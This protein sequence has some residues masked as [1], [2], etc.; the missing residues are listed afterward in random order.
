MS[1]LFG[2]VSQSGYVVP[3]LD[4]AIEA[5]A[6][7][8][9]GPWI[10]HRHVELEWFR[11]RGDD[12]EPDISI[13]L[14]NSGSLQIELIA[15]HNDAPTLY[16]EFLDAHPQGGQQ[17]LGF[18]LDDFEPARQR[19]LD[20]GWEVG[21]EGRMWGIDFAYFESPDAHPGLIVE[22]AHLDETQR[23]AAA[24]LAGVC[25]AWGGGDAVLSR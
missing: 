25:A 16:R 13:A 18:W 6:S 10:V 17:H 11:H 23:V 19:A 3:D 20:E 24:K 12:S 1:R 7:A 2:P 14:S 21:H 9:I 5:W 8:G 22:L 15:Q 4:A